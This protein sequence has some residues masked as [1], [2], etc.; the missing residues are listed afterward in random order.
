ME[1]NKRTIK[2]LTLAK[3]KKEN[4]VSYTRLQKI[5]LEVSK[6][7]SVKDYKRGYYCTN[8]CD[9][10]YKNLITKD[11][12]YYNLT[13]LGESYLKNPQKANLKIRQNKLLISR[14]HWRQKANN[15]YYENLQYRELIN[16]LKIYLDKFRLY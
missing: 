12:K 3:L 5:V 13:T 11:G 9:W 4:K 14:N 2:Y 15:L 16:D 1:N 8:I 6:K 10:K 7:D